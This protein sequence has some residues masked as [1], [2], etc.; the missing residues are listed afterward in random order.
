MP[1]LFKDYIYLLRPEQWLKN[2][3][4][5]APPFFGGVLFTSSEMVISMI[6]AFIAFSL[7]SSTAYVTNDISDIESDRLHPKKK[8]RPLASGRVGVT[9][10]TVLAVLTL[11]ISLVLSFWVNKGFLL[12]TVVYIVLSLL[13]SFYF[14]RI[15]IVDAFIIAIGFVLR[16]EAGGLAS[17]IEVTRWLLLTTFLLSLLLVFGK[18]RFEL[19]LVNNKGVKFRKV[20]AQYN[21]KFLDTALGIFAT[22]ALVTYSI[23]VV[24]SES[25]IFLITIPFACYGILRYMYLV[26]T[27]TSGD[28]TESLLKDKW[29]F[30]CV[31]IWLLITS[32]I[33]YF[34]DISG[35]IE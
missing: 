6:L 16:I 4:V 30:L 25:K 8:L 3:L 20:L 34:Q 22:S 13:Y 24:G 15:V 23:Y 29:L 14:E 18:R 5:L 32:L 21:E 12:I 7:A 28:P 19:T 35:L 11:I 9:E 17:G 10:A 27:D 1:G 33:I 26:Q 2:L 31:V